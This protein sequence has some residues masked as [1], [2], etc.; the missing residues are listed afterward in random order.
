MT[1]GPK[2]GESKTQARVASRLGPPRSPSP[3]AATVPLSAGAML[4]RT[5]SKRKQANPK[6]QSI[7]SQPFGALARQS[8]FALSPAAVES[9]GKAG[10]PALIPAPCD[11]VVD[12]EW[13]TVGSKF[14]SR[15]VTRSVLGADGERVR[16]QLG[17]IAGWLGARESD[18]VNAKGKAA[19]LYRTVYVGSEL[20]GDVEDLELHEAT[21][22][23]WA[24]SCNGCL[25]ANAPSLRARGEMRPAAVPRHVPYRQHSP[26]TRPRPQRATCR[27]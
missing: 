15:W 8:S 22:A 11:Y 27:A 6:R 20:D 9:V 4:G 13:R 23:L 1:F 5:P 24:H 10:P 3:A 21:S 16:D 14:L 25:R 19:S 17:F 2:R 7:N 18:F 26:R 12:P